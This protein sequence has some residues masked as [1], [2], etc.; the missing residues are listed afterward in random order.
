MKKLLTT[1]LMIFAPVSAFADVTGSGSGLFNTFTTNGNIDSVYSAFQRMALIC[2][3][4]EY[5]AFC[6]VAFVVSMIVT[7]IATF[8]KGLG[9]S[10]NTGNMMTWALQALAGLILYVGFIHPTTNINI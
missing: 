2:S 5:Q 4:S 7:A 9:F 1:V 10:I 6:M 8:S 3:H